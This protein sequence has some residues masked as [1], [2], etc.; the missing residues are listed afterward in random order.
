MINFQ[1]TYLS[2]YDWAIGPCLRNNSAT[3]CIRGG[4][5]GF[6][7][8]NDLF[9]IHGNGN[10]GIGTSSPSKTLHVA[11]TSIIGS[12]VNNITPAGVNDPSI[13]C[14]SIVLHNLSLIHI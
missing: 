6:S 8:L 12:G 9:A 10:V 7:N 3:F 13:Q 2:Y 14:Q 11:G 5:N 4:N 1:N